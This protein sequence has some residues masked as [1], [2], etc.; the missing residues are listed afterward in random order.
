MRAK[1]NGSF[2]QRYPG[3]VW[4]NSQASDSVMIRAALARPQAAVLKAIAEEFG[5]ERL[6]GEWEIMAADPSGILFLQAP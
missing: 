5:S 4:S 6:R 1:R 3:L 2:W